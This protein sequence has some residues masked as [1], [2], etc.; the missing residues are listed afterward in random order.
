MNP[1]IKT[2][3]DSLLEF[4]PTQRPSIS[5]LLCSPLF[6][7]CLSANSSCLE[8]KRMSKSQ[9]KQPNQTIP[10]YFQKEIE[11]HQN[12]LKNISSSPSPS[13]GF[14][15]LNN[16][17]YKILNIKTTVK[18]PEIIS[19]KCMVYSPAKI[20]PS[21]L[22]KR[23]ITIMKSVDFKAKNQLSTFDNNVNKRTAVMRS[24]QNNYFNSTTLLNNHTQER[25]NNNTQEPL[26]NDN[27]TFVERTPKKKILKYEKKKFYSRK[28]DK[29]FEQ[30]LNHNLVQNSF[31]QPQIKPVEIRPKQISRSVPKSPYKETLIGKEVIIYKRDQSTGKIIRSNSRTIYEYSNN[32]HDKN[33]VSHNNNNNSRTI[34][35]FVPFHSSHKQLINSQ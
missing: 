30:H 25:L 9:H 5:K 10:K 19:N 21:P 18:S 26:H 15:T 33:N 27:N 34:N 1:V 20:S 13:N 4:E 35:N 12:Y 6:K 14:I 16:K 23:N 17:S 11:Y 2:T 29:N 22:N 24:P 28:K 7:L 3:I 31:H 32:N 8:Y